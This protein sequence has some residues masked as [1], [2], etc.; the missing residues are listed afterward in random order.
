MDVKRWPTYADVFDWMNPDNETKK[1]Q[2]AEAIIKGWLSYNERVDAKF[3]DVNRLVE[4]IDAYDGDWTQK[5]IFEVAC[6]IAGV[7]IDSYETEW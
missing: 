2:I 1:E 3:L 7:D 5:S 4:A 6:E